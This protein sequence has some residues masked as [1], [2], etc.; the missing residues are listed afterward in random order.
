V[1]FAVATRAD[2]AAIRR[3]LRENPM[4]G[5]ISVTF[6]REPDYFHGANLA[7]GNDEVIVAI[8]HGRLVCM[9]RCTTRAVWLNG[10]VR[11]AGYLAELRLDRSA[12]GRVDLLRR[13]YRFFQQ[14]REGDPADFYFTS[15][16][17]DNVRA[18][19]L[20]ERGLPGLPCYLHLADLTTLLVST[21]TSVTPK[22]IPDSATAAELADFLNAAGS[23]THLAAAWTSSQL[24]TEASHDLRAESFAVFRDHGRIV[25]A[26][27]LWDQRRFRQTVVRE[28]APALACA[29]PLINTFGGLFG[30]GPLPQPGRPLA[31]AFLSPCA[32]AA[33]DD[34]LL[35]S[36]VAL[37]C[38]RAFAQGIDYV[39]LALPSDDARLRE[40]KRQFRWRSYA[41]RLYCVRWPGDADFPLDHR[42]VLPDVALL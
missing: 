23:R 31:H 42:P 15:I 13:G 26:A 17:A 7:G 30:L 16:A 39:T 4:R 34:R 8:E 22:I 1:R 6:E 37:S 18:R 41:S 38:R 12:Q 36:L 5:T 24:D 25:A 27:A 29:R 28:Y 20:L 14:L 11:R 10:R 21:R 32:A 40:L 19:Q 3:L 35:T 9:G 2:E 33:G